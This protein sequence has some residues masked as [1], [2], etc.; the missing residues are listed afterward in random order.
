MQNPLD[1]DGPFAGIIKAL[2]VVA[3]LLA[4]SSWILVWPFCMGKGPY[5]II[6]FFGYIGA[7]AMPFL[8]I[9]WHATKGDTEPK[10]ALDRIF[11]E[12]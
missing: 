12:H 11:E 7:S 9:A 1:Y 2:V 8:I 10:N 5:G 3:M 4:T 6:A